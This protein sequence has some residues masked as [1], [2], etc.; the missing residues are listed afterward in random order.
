MT[1]GRGLRIT[2]V[3][4]NL[5]RGGLERVVIDLAET[6]VRLGYDCQ[7]VC[8]FER[9]TLAEE[10]EAR[11]VRV[12][13]C[14]KRRGIDL[15]AVARMRHLLRTH[16]SDVVHTHN[17]AAHY[18]AALAS[19]GLHQRLVNTR[20]GMGMLASANRREWLY[21]LALRRTAAVV[22]VC[23]AARRDVERA[24]TLPAGK[25]VAIPNGIDVSRFEATD[26]REREKLVSALGLPPRTRLIGTVGRLNW[27]KNH[28]GLARAFIELRRDMPDCALVIVGDGALRDELAAIAASSGGRVL[29][30]GDRG[31][32]PALLRGFDVFAMSSLTEGYSIALLEAC[33]AGLPIVATDVGGNAEIVRDGINGRIVPPN[34]DGALAGAL[35]DLLADPAGALAMG[36]AGREWVQTEGSLVAMA[37]RYESLYVGGTDGAAG[38][39]QR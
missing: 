34:D 13:A 6:Q 2:H 37:K 26:E 9:G 8:L 21:G 35:R 16:H 4:E 5:N 30:L 3:V 20:H 17:A 14:G 29:P 38:T 32:I 31:D 27:A 23:E 33:A 12:H 15:R 10:M 28:A 36:R 25:L 18:Y 22:T 7:V 19:L 39:P 24:G 11:G 1:P